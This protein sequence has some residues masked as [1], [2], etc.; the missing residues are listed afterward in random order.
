MKISSKDAAL[1]TVRERDMLQSSGP[2]HVSDLVSLIK[3]LR[4]LRDK[5]RQ[6]G[7]R[8]VV[9][10]ARA[11]KGKAAPGNRSV[12]KGRLLDR[13]LKHFEAELAAINKQSTA[14]AKALRG[15]AKPVKK[16][17]LSKPAKKKATKKATAKKAA[18]KATSPKSA[19]K[20]AVKKKAAAKKAATKK[21]AAKKA[22]PKKAATKKTATKKTSTKKA[23]AAKP[24]TKRAAPKKAA[25]TKSAAKKATAKKAAP[26]KQSV[27][28]KSAAA[29][30][31][32]MAP[33]PAPTPSMLPGAATHPAHPGPE[34]AIS[35][36]ARLRLPKGGHGEAPSQT[37]SQPL[38]H[39]RG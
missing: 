12:D 33:T 26:A 19:P 3:R 7:Q 34:Q 9:A 21:A 17:T 22:A 29:R 13:A 39:R 1:L 6:L 37:H 31:A 5:Q 4:D 27:A 15:A 28:K 24:A 14:A 32:T 20:K 30:E 10:S 16:A 35:A 11:A 23:A 18:K 25:A 8:Q 2:W 36:K 38:L